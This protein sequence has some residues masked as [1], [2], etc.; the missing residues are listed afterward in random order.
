MINRVLKTYF[1]TIIK[2]LLFISICLIL[3]GCATN[4]KNETHQEKTTIEPIDSIEVV[5]TKKD[6]IIRINLGFDSELLKKDEEN[7]LAV[8]EPK[9]TNY[10][11]QI[12]DEYYFPAS[13]SI[14]AKDTIIGNYHFVYSLVSIKNRIIVTYS[15]HLNSEKGKF[16][17]DKIKYRDYFIKFS[18]KN[19]MTG[20]Q[21]EKNVYKTN[22][23]RL[24]N[25]ELKYEFIRDVD[26]TYQKNDTFFFAIIVSPYNTNQIDLKINLMYNPDNNLI[27][28]DYPKSF[29]D[30]Y[31]GI[32]Y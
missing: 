7:A 22:I 15:E 18:A 17:R 29:Y 16:V 9:K 19:L 4:T 28:E 32:D 24:V 10:N 13:D 12:D 1:M 27:I 23:A 21:F 14:M 2:S 6:S 25:S 30:S 20:E 11:P 5:E 26:F 31:W 8:I 3:F